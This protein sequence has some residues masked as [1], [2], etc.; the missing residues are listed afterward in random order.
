[1]WDI[2]VPSWRARDVRREIDVV[3]EVARFKLESVPTTLPVREAMFGRLTHFQR[4]RRQVEDVLVGAGFY[5]AYTYSL[6]PSDPDPRAIELPVPLSSQ[7]R[8]LR[9]NLVQG[10]VGAARHNVD[11]GNSGVRL[12]EVAH[13]YLPPA[14]GRSKV[15][16]ER[17]HVGGI[18]DGPFAD[19]KG[20]VEGIFAAL[21]IEP[22]FERAQVLP[23][24]P[25]GAT[26]QSGWVAQHAFG[27]IDGVWSAFE[28]DLA[29]LFEQVP[30]RILYRDVITYPPLREDLAFVV[31]EGAPAG[32][33]MRAAREA[34]GEELREVRFLSDYRGEPIP[35]GSKSV[36]LGFVFQSPER[37]LSD[38]DAVR[39]RAAIVERLADEFDAQ[40]RT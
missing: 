29:E 7:Q 22:R 16:R 20:V 40:L 13:V 10:L 38:A 25:V 31:A 28:L 9:T 18:V 35:V 30:E 6:Q 4:L 36:A 21:K 26:V 11:M 1:M 34:A 17:W 32:D 14:R 12:F 33:L 3:E 15:P 8:F 2:T 23:Q 39:L 37:T 27:T 5:E 19:A 24:S